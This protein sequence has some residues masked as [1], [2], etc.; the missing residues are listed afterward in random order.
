METQRRRGSPGNLLLLRNREHQMKS[1]LQDPP[2][3]AAACL[4][5]GARF[6]DLTRLSRQRYKQLAKTKVAGALLCSS[7]PLQIA[8]IPCLDSRTPLPDNGRCARL[9]NDCN[10][11][12]V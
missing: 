4:K 6:R 7:R 8:E 11:R 5:I 9:S 1:Q 3:S 12:S 10:A 2:E